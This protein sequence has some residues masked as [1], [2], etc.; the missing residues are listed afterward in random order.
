VFAVTL[1]A[2][3][4]STV[5]VDYATADGS[6]GAPGDYVAAS[7]TLT[8]T[9]GQTA[10]QIIVAVK[11][12]TLN[13]VN[14]TYTVNL[15]NPSNATISG[16]GIGTGTITNDDAVP[17]LSINNVSQAEGNSGT[18]SYTFTVTLSTAS[19]LP[20][21][22]DFATADGTAAAPGDYQAQSGTLT[23]SP[24]QA[25]KTITILVNGDVSIEPSETFLVLLSSPVNATVTGTGI[26]TGT[27][28]NDD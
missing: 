16:T 3:S 22:V 28:T 21:S 11:G 17:T 13:E 4:A 15:T 25:T 23:F 9:A 12:E 5:T 1:S 18:T 20:V 19:G 8:F 6:A 27:I 24:G 26:G 7:G 10:K 2:V 14:E